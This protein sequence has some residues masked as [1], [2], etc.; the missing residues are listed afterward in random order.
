MNDFLKQDIFFFVTTIAVI[1]LT[2]LLCVLIIYIIKISKDI[3]YISQKAKSEADLISQ[4]L[5]ELRDNVK[6]KGAKL[7]YFISFFNN[8]GKKRDKK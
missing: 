2:L 5:S 6:E 7:K 3:K 8:L 4:D 1:L